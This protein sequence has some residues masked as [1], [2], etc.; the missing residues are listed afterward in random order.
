MHTTNLDQ[1]KVLRNLPAILCMIV[2]LI[3]MVVS[4]PVSAATSTSPV[5]IT[6]VIK[7]QIPIADFYGDLPLTGP[8][9]LTISFH[10][11]SQGYIISW[12]WEFGDGT[13]SDL[14][15]PPSHTYFIGKSYTVNLTVSNSAG[16]STKSISNYITVNSPTITL[17]PTV[18]PAGVGGIAYPAATTITAS[19]GTGPYTYAVTDGLLP[20]GLTLTGGTISGTPTVAGTFNFNL[21]AT[22]F[23]GFTGL[24]A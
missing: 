16:F 7:D 13:I 1:N 17:S 2:I 9:P 11:S 10:D 22:D 3:C 12:H 5:I 21:T 6:A 15:N 23:Y 20:T 4:Q 18:L 8:S 14:Q 24:Q 19:G